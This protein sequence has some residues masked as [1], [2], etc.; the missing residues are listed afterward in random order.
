MLRLNDAS[1]GFAN[2]PRACRD[3]LTLNAVSADWKVDCL[4]S[5]NLAPRERYVPFIDFAIPELPR[6]RGMGAVVFRNHHQT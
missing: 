1:D 3:P 2:V 6:E 4:S 5:L